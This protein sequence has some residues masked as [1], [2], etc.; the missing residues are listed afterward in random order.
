MIL[1][2]IIT[3]Y[4]AK[5]ETAVVHLS[6]VDF[7]KSAVNCELKSC[8]RFSSAVSHNR[9]SSPFILQGNMGVINGQTDR[10]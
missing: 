7:H 1:C 6:E 8:S 2:D 4:T 5:Q 3:M 9:V 10:N